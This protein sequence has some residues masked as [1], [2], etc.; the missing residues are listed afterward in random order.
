M[1]KNNQ[2]KIQEYKF[3]RPLIKL[4]KILICLTFLAFVV[5]I[6]GIEI[7]TKF[8]NEATVFISKTLEVKDFTMPPITICM[9]NGYKPSVLKKQGVTNGFYYVFDIGWN[10]NITS[11]WDSYL[12]ASYLL[13]KD[14]EID[15]VG[16]LKSSHSP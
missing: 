14:F 11:V 6:Y 15:I 7:F 12:N 2:N 1:S 3:K 4:L 10:G 9:K 8:G 16:P 13:N 5:Y